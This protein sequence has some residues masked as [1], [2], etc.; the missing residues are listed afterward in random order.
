MNGRKLQLSQPSICNMV[1]TA[2]EKQLIQ[3][4]GNDLSSGMEVTNTLCI[5]E[6]ELFDSLSLCS[7]R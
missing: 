5:N 3:E 7:S 4:V 6:N 1:R 2:Q